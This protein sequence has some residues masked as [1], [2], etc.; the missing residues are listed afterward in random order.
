M[1]LHKRFI[2]LS[3]VVPLFLLLTACGY[4]FTADTGTQLAAGQTAWVAYFKNSTVYPSA[5]VAIKRALFEQLA[6]QRNIL[7]ASSEKQGDLLFSGKITG[8]D[9]AVV[10]YT[11]ADFA[12]EYRL[13]LTAAVT[14]EKQGKVGNKEMIWQGAISAWQDYVV[15]GSIE[16]QRR[17]EEAALQAA[18]NKLAQQ[19]IWQM[20]QNY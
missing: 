19:V 14:A 17:N 5:T 16:E 8:Y 4:H 6:S 12:Q 9:I 13:T 2:Y 11:A 7:P 20:E 3:L 15:T 18:A 1:L 10:S